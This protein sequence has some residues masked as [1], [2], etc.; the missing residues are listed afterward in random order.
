METNARHTSNMIDGNVAVGIYNGVYKICG[1]RRFN[2]ARSRGRTVYCSSGVTGNIVLI[3]NRNEQ[4]GGISLIEVS[5]YGLQHLRDQCLSNP[6]DNGGTCQ[7]NGT[8]YD[9]ICPPNWYGSNC[10]GKNCALGQNVEMSSL[11]RPAFKSSSAVDGNTI[12]L[13]LHAFKFYCVFSEKERNPL[14]KIQFG[15]LLEARKIVI[16]NR[17]DYCSMNLNNFEIR[18]GP[19]Q[20]NLQDVVL[21]E[22]TWQ[23]LQG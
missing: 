8:F 1:T 19:F 13:N 4:F 11:L 9:C 3:V 12:N 7:T 20:Q 23:I 6:C 16:V 10:D 22:I 15:E 5:V 2:M 17:Q 21:R 18:I 14:K